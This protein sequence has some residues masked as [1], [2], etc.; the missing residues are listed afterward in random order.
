LCVLSR[1]S[2]DDDNIV[3]SSFAGASGVSFDTKGIDNG[4]WNYIAGVGYDVNLDSQNN[5]N[6]Q[7]NYQGEGSKYSNNVISLNYMYKF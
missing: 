7:Y 1:K 3:T 2:G 5:L 4:R 6:V